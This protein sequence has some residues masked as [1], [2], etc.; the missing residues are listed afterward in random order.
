LF[1][2]IFIVFIQTSL[3]SFSI[4]HYIQ[5]SLENS[6]DAKLINDNELSLKLDYDFQKN[7]FF[8]N[9][10]PSSYFTANEDSNTLS[11][12]IARDQANKYAG[13]FYNHL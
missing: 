5:L 11:M 2:I 12:G 7:K 3:F 9:Y 10:S 6:N 13:C 4:F 1:K 8:S